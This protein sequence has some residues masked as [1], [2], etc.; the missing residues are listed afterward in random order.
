MVGGGDEPFGRGGAERFIR[1][2][3]NLHPPIDP[4]TY[5]RSDPIAKRESKPPELTREAIRIFSSIRN[6]L[7]D[8]LTRPIRLT[9]VDV[10]RT[11]IEER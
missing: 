7:P 11:S 2:V 8:S 4:L 6:S 10:V 9:D 5:P 3:M 1:G